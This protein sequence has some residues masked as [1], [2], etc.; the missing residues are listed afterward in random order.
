[1]MK[2]A[3]KIFENAKLLSPILLFLFGVI[4]LFTVVAGIVYAAAGYSVK[5]PG[6]ILI[7]I[8]V[9]AMMVYALWP[10]LSLEE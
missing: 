5:I 1:M 7:A 8:F 2:R 9:M 4:V 6:L 3:S 10:L